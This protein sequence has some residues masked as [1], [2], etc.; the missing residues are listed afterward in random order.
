[1]HAELSQQASGKPKNVAPAFDTP[2]NLF[3]DTSKGKQMYL[4]YRHLSR[5]VHPSVTTFGRYTERPPYGGLHL[6]TRLEVEQDDE[7]VAY[8]L[9]SAMVLCALAYLDALGEPVS[10]AVVAAA[11]LSGVLTT[12]DD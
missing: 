7:A 10:A 8:Y 6:S 4:A 3:G 9:A 2:K 5:F 1:V 11:R 12:L